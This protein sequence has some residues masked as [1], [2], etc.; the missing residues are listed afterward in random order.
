MCLSF[1]F[2][3]GVA[4]HSGQCCQYL[5]E[6]LLIDRLDSHGGSRSDEWRGKLG[7]RPDKRLCGEDTRSSGELAR[8]SEIYG[9]GKNF[10]Q[11]KRD[12]VKLE[13]RM[14]G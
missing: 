4:L 9:K 13:G 3:L 5:A 6:A 7:V 14:D 10:A 11:A 8:L 2:P 12:S 1:L